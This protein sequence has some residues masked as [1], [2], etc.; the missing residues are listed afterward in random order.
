M[1]FSK[2]NI[3]C[4]LIFQ[5]KFLGGYLDERIDF[6]KCNVFQVHH[7][8]Y[9]IFWDRRIHVISFS[10]AAALTSRRRFIRS[11]VESPQMTS[12]G[13]YGLWRK[14]SP[15]LSLFCCN[16]KQHDDDDIFDITQSCTFLGS[17]FG[18]RKLLKLQRNTAKS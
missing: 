3:T 18:K 11:K 17:C 7:P 10:A 4:A 8:K 15:C 13:L 2:N 6:S 12:T 5:T 14:I 9:F 1:G 16:R